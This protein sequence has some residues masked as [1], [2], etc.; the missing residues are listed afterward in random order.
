MNENIQL[1]SKHNIRG[2]NVLACIVL[3][4]TLTTFVVC[5]KYILKLDNLTIIKYF[6]FQLLIYLQGGFIFKRFKFKYSKLEEFI[7]SLALGITFTIIQYVIF[8]MLNIPKGVMISIYLMSILSAFEIVYNTV[9]RKNSLKISF[10]FSKKH[11]IL[12]ILLSSI[13]LLSLISL[14]LNNL[15]PELGG[16]NSYNQ[17]LLW[18]IGNASN[19]VNNFP[20][21]DIRLSGFPLNYHYFMHIHVAVMSQFLDISTFELYTYLSHFHKLALYILSMFLFGEKFLKSSK[22]ALLLVGI[23]FFTGSLSLTKGIMYSLNTNY[24][25]VLMNPFGFIFSMTFMLLCFSIFI[26]QAQHKKIEINSLVL[27]LIF[28]AISCGSKGPVGILIIGAFI[29]SYLLYMIFIRDDYK[30]LLLKYTLFSLCIF[31][32][33]YI[34]FIGSGKQSLSFELGYFAKSTLVGK[35]VSTLLLNI[36]IPT[37]VNTIIVILIHFIFY[38]PFGAMFFIAWSIIKLKSFKEIEIKSLVVAGYCVCGIFLSYIFRHSGH[39]EMY[40]VMSAIPFI[41][42]CA[43][44]FIWNISKKKFL[45]IISVIILILS[46]VS[47]LTPFSQ[48]TVSAF[49]KVKAMDTLNLEE[50]SYNFISYYEYEGMKWLRANTNTDDII[51]GDRHYYTK[52]IEPEDRRPARYF[53][54]SAFSERQF[55]LEGWAYNTTSEKY[56]EQLEYKKHICDSIYNE[57]STDALNQAIREGVEYIILSS[58]ETPDTE[59]QYDNIELVF[60]NRDIKIYKIKA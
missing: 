6:I 20:A 11:S 40:F 48:K 23:Y 46:S 10:R 1:K 3:F 58:F 60:E 35:K 2:I 4:I 38:M 24:I 51:L 26:D 45:K 25:H 55:F 22:K 44:D 21:E 16:G 37:F 32:F 17:D 15:S 7:Y 28:L 50:P 56:D 30:K 59:L 39:S 8:Y 41:N 19:M 31:L 54:Y 53:Y 34:F 5:W 49:K 9:K 47:I 27:F 12:I 57:N 43:V 14:S 13:L 36:G 29:G 42:A 18:N 52:D 33:I